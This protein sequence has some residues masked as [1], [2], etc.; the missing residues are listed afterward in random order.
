MPGQEVAVVSPLIMPQNDKNNLLKSDFSTLET[1]EN[2]QKGSF[3]MITGKTKI[4][5]PQRQ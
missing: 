2:V 4:L 3:I 1:I 5:Y